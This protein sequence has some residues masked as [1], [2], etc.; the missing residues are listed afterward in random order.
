[1]FPLIW[2]PRWY[3]HPSLIISEKSYVR[4]SAFLYRTCSI[5]G[6]IPYIIYFITIWYLRRICNFTIFKSDI[7]SFCFW[8]DS[9]V[10]TSKCSN[11]IFFNMF[12]ILLL[13]PI[14]QQKQSII[15][16]ISSGISYWVSSSSIINEL[17]YLSKVS[18]IPDG[19]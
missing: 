4:F 11:Q 18:T 19:N 5:I 17:S 14:I 3:H 6:L 15:F 1:M 10:P 13:Y 2:W 12:I 7:V 9:H 8:K 16:Q